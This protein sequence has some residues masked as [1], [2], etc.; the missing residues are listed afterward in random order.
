MNMLADWPVKNNNNDVL[1]ALMMKPK[2]YFADPYFTNLF[3]ISPDFCIILRIVSLTFEFASSSA[4][5]SDIAS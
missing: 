2:D 4:T 5:A 1:M 3:Y